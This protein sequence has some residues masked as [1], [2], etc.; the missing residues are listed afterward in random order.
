MADGSNDTESVLRGVREQRGPPAVVGGT[1]ME[2]FVV[3]LLLAL[4]FG[5]MLLGLRFTVG[6]L[7]PIIILVI[8]SMISTGG[9]SWL[10][11]GHILLALV[12]IQGGYLCG[13]AAA[14]MAEDAPAASPGY[15][16]GN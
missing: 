1:E 11:A 8:V 10:N 12:A 3:V 2:T 15:A 5:G 4:S 16:R 6:L 14:A 7:F 9:V 13:V